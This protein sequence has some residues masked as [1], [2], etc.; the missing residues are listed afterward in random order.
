MGVSLCELKSVQPSAVAPDSTDE[1]GLLHSKR[2]DCRVCREVRGEE[3][4]TS[5]ALWWVLERC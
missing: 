3:V 4:T 5:R 1:P 2:N